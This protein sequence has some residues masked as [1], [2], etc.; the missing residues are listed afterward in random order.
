MKVYVVEIKIG[1]KTI[2]EKI[3]AN[4]ELEAIDMAHEIHCE[5]DIL[6]IKVI[7]EQ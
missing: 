4:D 5:D 2:T 3:R 1:D 7:A 6:D